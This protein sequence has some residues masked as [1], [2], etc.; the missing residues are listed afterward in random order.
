[1]QVPRVPEELRVDV[2]R[3]EGE[4]DGHGR[5]RLR[6]AGALQRHGRTRTY[7]H[8][9]RRP[10]V[11]IASSLTRP[12]LSWHSTTPTPTPTLR[13]SDGHPRDDPRRHVRHARFPEVIPVAS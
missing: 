6:T 4:H 10:S 2:G 1:M 9:R 7:R 3:G 8:R 13:R 12:L 5:V 11:Y